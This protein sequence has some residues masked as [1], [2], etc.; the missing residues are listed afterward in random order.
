MS[1]VLRSYRLKSVIVLLLCLLL[2][3]CTAGPAAPVA[4]LPDL[5]G[6]WVGVYPC[7][8]NEI[9]EITQRGHRVQATKLTGDAFVPAGE[10][11]WR[12]SVDSGRGEGQLADSGFSNARFVSGQLVLLDADT[13]QFEWAGSLVVIFSR[14]D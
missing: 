13:L 7:C 3:A 14:L 6:R 11:T 4:A 12:A 5:R 8:G 2:P 10:V 9:V 1:A